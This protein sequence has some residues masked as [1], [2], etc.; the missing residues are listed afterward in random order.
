MRRLPRPRIGALIRQTTDNPRWAYLARA[1]EIRECAEIAPPGY[2]GVSGLL[3]LDCEGK[4]PRP[5]A[6]GLLEIGAN[7]TAGKIRHS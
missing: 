7:N 2:L 4:H 1:W 3:H 5:S 6:W